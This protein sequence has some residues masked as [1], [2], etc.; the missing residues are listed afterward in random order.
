MAR[1]L[2]LLLLLAAGCAETPDPAASA[3]SGGGR[4]VR[5]ATTTSVDNSGLLDH[6]LPP[7]EQRHGISVHVISVG[8]GK[9]L[10]LGASG[11]VDVLILHDPQGEE[12]F[13]AAG[14]GVNRQ[15]FMHNDF[16]LL[17]PK[18]DPAGAGAAGRIGPAL[19]AVAT[20][21]SSFVSRGDDSGTY[22]RERSLWALAGIKPEG[23]WYLEVGQGMGPTLMIADE[24]QAYVLVDRGT[25]LA[26]GDKI[27]LRPVYQGGPRL[28]NPYSIVVVNPDR[29]KHVNYTGAIQ[30]VGWV[31]SRE[32]QQIIA[33]FRK[34][35]RQLFVPDMVTEV[36]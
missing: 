27:T 19:A 7:F 23:S 15:T 6:L 1:G 10:M 35:G 30:L 25:Y 28:A 26:F 21:E 29:W 12:E 8:T 18:D 14:L 24:K 33:R 11:D 20:A 31:T 36:R 22:R 32:G 5:L 9:A 13:V 17:G 4:P 34:N 2:C 16:L 3:P